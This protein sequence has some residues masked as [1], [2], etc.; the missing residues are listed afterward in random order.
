MSTG[1]TASLRKMVFR[2]KGAG[3]EMM[4]R[5]RSVQAGE[6]QVAIASIQATINNEK[7]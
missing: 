2:K 5:A 4:G 6:A 3:E 7:P 1:V